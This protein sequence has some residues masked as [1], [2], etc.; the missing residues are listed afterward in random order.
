MALECSAAGRRARP[1]RP[2]VLLKERSMDNSSIEIVTR[3]NK[4]GDL[5][6]SNTG[7]FC[8]RNFKRI[9]Y[10]FGVRRTWR[11]QEPIVLQPCV[12]PGG[13]RDEVRPETRHRLSA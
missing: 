10:R 8:H 6:P 11:P 1:I 9:Q 13:A 5:W 7:P 4:R 2:P 3:L 12:R